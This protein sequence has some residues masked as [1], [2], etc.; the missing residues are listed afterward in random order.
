MTVT[1]TVLVPIDQTVLTFKNGATYAAP[2]KQTFSNLNDLKLSLPVSNRYATYEPN[3]W[4]LDGSYKFMPA[5]PVLGYMSASM[6]NGA[7]TMV[8]PPT[9]TITLASAY[10]I[11]DGLTLYFSPYTNDYADSI[12]IRYYDVSNALIR[13]DSYTPTGPEFATGQAVS[14]VKK[15]EIDFN[16]TNKANRYIR[17]TGIDLDSFITIGKESIKDARLIEEINPPCVE[18]PVNTVTVTLFSEDADF[19]IVDPAGFYADLQYR[20]PFDIYELVDGEPI[21]MGRFYLEEWDARSQNEITLKMIDV[22]GVLELIPYPGELLIGVTAD[23]YMPA[24]FN[25]AG[26]GS[27]MISVD[28]S[29]ASQTILLGVLPPTNYREALQYFCFGIGAYATCTRSNIIHVR[30][31]EIAADLV[32]FDHTLTESEK[33]ID[34]PVRLRNLVTGIEVV[35]HDYVQ[36]A[37]TVAEVLFDQDLAIGTHIILFGKPVYSLTHTATGGLLGGA[38]IQNTH[39]IRTVT[40]AGHLLI[41]GKPYVDNKKT[42]SLYNTGLPA[43]TQP[44]VIRIDDATTA[45]PDNVDSIVQSLYDYYEQRYIQKTKL[46]ASLIAPGDS[47]LINTQSNKQ[48]QGIVEKMT[49]DLARGMVSDV[50]I[51]GIVAP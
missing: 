45:I 33:G 43:G 17:L 40:A 16:S 12:T 22:I 19:S 26:I 3:F 10:S 51:V 2:D 11:V 34:S 29:L 28:A 5:V 48:I 36:A 18:L 1:S 42:I 23:I 27:D 41:T 30:P 8:V 4:V 38:T 46:F 25:N 49:T 14:S 13:T 6:S 50:E 31:L 20:A 44:N 7:T 39:E 35:S 32:T 24:I 9:L 37:D 15:I 21:Y 47:V